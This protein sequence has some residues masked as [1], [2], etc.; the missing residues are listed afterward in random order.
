MELIVSADEDVLVAR[1]FGASNQVNLDA[2]WIMYPFDV[3]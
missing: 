3:T 2:G 1:G